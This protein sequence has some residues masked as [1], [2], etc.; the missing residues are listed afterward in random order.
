MTPL[1][2][3][4][5]DLAPL[6]QAVGPYLD[7]FGYFAIFFGVLLEDFGIPLPGETM[8]VTGALFASLGSFKIEW[9]GLLGFFGAIIGDNI[10]YAVGRYAGRRVVLKY[11]RF[12]FLN[13]ERL[14]K[15]ESFFARHGGK[16][17]IVARFVEGLRQ[18]NGIVA[19]LSRMEWRRFLLFNV[20]GAAI[21]VGVW[22]CAAY[23]LASQ[24]GVILSGFK[25]FE[26]YILIGLAS[27]AFVALSYLLIKWLA[28]RLRHR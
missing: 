4:L 6:I 15:F 13:E 20:V 18:F 26:K 3:Q 21:W 23:F 28:G 27:A 7:R 17:V 16:I 5:K 24:L 8:L 19:G 14:H 9:V 12:V 2:P 25:R 10:G 11:G 22:T 1:P